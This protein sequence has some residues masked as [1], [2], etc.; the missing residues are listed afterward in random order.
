MN[1]NGKSG[2]QPGEGSERGEVREHQF[3]VLNQ[4]P[5]LVGHPRAIDLTSLLPMVI[6]VEWPPVRRKQ[7]TNSPLCSAE[8]FYRTTSGARRTA[9]DITGKYHGA[10]VCEH[11]GRLIE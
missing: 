11:M 5:E 10:F 6:W 7:F 3:E 8:I 2:P 9:H 4:C 1:G